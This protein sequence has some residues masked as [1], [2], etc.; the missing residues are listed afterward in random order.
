[1]RVFWHYTPPWLWGHPTRDR[2]LGEAWAEAGG[3][4]RGVGVAGPVT[5]GRPGDDQNSVDRVT[6]TVRRGPGRKKAGVFTVV[7]I[8]PR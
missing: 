3:A 2:W 6:C 7:L 8:V 5:H 4:T 1:M